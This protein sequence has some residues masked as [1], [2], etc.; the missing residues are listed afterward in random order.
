MGSAAGIRFHV[1]QSH[2]WDGDAVD[3]VITRMRT[4]HGMNEMTAVAQ[5]HKALHAADE[6]M[7]AQPNGQGPCDNCHGRPAVVILTD[8]R[9]CIECATSRPA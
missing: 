9:F 6:A 1:M 8:G 3:R 4:E 2:K 7:R 5:L